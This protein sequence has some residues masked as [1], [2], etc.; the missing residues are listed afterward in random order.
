MVGKSVSRMGK[1]MF[2]VCPHLGE[3]ELPARSSWGGGGTLPG[4]AGGGG[5]CQVQPGGG[6]CLGGYQGRV[7]PG[8]VRIGGGTQLVQQK[9]YSLHD[10]R[11]ASYV[12]AGGLFLLYRFSS[13]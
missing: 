8:Q 3:G 10:G 2:S 4:P 7:P 11:Y 9:E 13:G 12:H 6:T 5:I 1:V